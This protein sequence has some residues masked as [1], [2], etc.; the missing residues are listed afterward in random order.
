MESIHIGHRKRM[1]AKYA[2]HGADIFD[3]HELLEMLLYTVIPYRDTNPIAHELLRRFG[4]L[5]GIAA[6]ESEALAAVPGVGSRT[7]K[8]LAGTLSAGEDMFFP[9]EDAVREKLTYRT[10]GEFLLPT[11]SGCHA[12]RTVMLSLD[13]R[14]RCISCDTVSEEDFGRGRAEVKDFVSLALG[15]HASAVVL[16]HTHPYGPL[17]PSEN[18]Y[19]RNSLV[20]DALAVSSVSLA[21][22][23]IFSGEKYVTFTSGESEKAERCGEPPVGDLCLTAGEYDRSVLTRL[24]SLV[25]GHRDPAADADR[26]LSSVGT[27]RTL[28]TLPTEELTAL[29]SERDAVY[30]KLV[31]SLASRRHTDRFP[32]GKAVT[33][34]QMT[35]YL[36][37]L[38]APLAEEC[39]YLLLF[40]ASDRLIASECVSRGTVN[41]SG[42]TPRRLMDIACRRGAASVILAHNHPNGYSKP[43][44]EDIALTTVMQSAFAAVGIALREHYVIAGDRFGRVGSEALSLGKNELHL[45][46]SLASAEENGVFCKE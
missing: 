39:V 31:A 19:T 35:D 12:Y 15:R 7:A 32:F 22:H 4:D 21:G 24:L 13:N 3:T 33:E 17:Y 11:L 29:L 25:P 34:R 43:S 45:A 20:K 40:D 26:L 30:L 14:M 28:V 16:A 46:S 5:D 23:Y 38:F 9:P 36:S 37:A 2:L 44:P 6:A 1:K 8:F 27:L 42:I 18:D 41:S 10:A